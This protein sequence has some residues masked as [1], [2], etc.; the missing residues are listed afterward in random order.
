MSLLFRILPLAALLGG[1]AAWRPAPEAIP[2]VDPAWTSQGF[3]KNLRSAADSA[4]AELRRAPEIASADIC[5][6]S[7]EEHAPLSV[8]AS[9][10]WASPASKER[11][12]ALLSAVKS[13]FDSF[14]RVDVVARTR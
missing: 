6:R 14:A 4:E 1:W 2:A 5:V 10:A 9:I 11:C 7:T 8:E 12:E 13:H 3:A